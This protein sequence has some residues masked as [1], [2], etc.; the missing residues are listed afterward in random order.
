M[1]KNVYKT[2]L[3]YFNLMSE[4]YLILVFGVGKSETVS[5]CKREDTELLV[6]VTS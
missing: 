1:G 2:L 3:C 5:P 4:D 6:T